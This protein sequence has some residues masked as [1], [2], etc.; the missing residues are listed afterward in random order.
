MK[1]FKPNSIEYCLISVDNIIAYFKGKFY[2]DPRSNSAA[3]KLAG[4]ECDAAGCFYE[5]SLNLIIIM[6]GKQLINNFM[7]IGFP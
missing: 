4:D 1:M 2:K 3:N 5:L 6:V 7:E